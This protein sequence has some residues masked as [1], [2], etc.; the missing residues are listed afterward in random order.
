[1]KLKFLILLMLV[2]AIS[3]SK[4]EDALSNNP[5]VETPPATIFKVTD[6]A[7]FSYKTYYQEFANATNRKGA[8]I[9]AH[10][11]GGSENDGT[12]NEQCKALAEAGY[13]GVTTSYRA[14]TF[15]G[16]SID[17]DRFKEDIENVINKIKIDYTIPINKIIVGGLSRGGNLAFNMFLPTTIYGS[18]TNLDVKGIVLECSG[19]EYY[20]G[21]A[22]K[23]QVAYMSNKIDNDVDGDAI[24]FQ[25]GLTVNVNNN[26][27]T[28]SE[29]LIINSTG[30]C[31]NADQYKP[32]ILRKV[33]EWLP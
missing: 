18:P 28:L 4:D 13:V 12:L 6:L 24:A 9:L 19:G 23:K 1:M 16:G 27:K 11:D 32:F 7:P 15:S 5:V 14:P 20:K 29:C 3:C 17:N 30:H 33:K 21:S 22:I 2:F 10:G 31:T 26:V 25:T 8:V